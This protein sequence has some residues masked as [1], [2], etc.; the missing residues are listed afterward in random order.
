M[1]INDVDLVTVTFRCCGKRRTVPLAELKQSP[2]R[3]FQ[4]QNLS[5][6]AVVYYNPAEF[7]A[8]INKNKGAPDLT[9]SLYPL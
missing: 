5:C 8:L 2:Q 4:C 9:I 6:G 1:L 3:Q 7:V